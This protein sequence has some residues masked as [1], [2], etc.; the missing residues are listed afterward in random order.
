MLGRL[1]DQLLP[2]HVDS[3]EEHRH[4]QSLLHV[5]DTNGEL[6]SAL[7]R[8]PAAYPW[9]TLLPFFDHSRADLRVV[10][11]ETSATTSSRKWP[12][13]A[14]NYRMHPAN[15]TVLTRAN[16]DYTSLANNHVL[17]FQAEGMRDTCEALDRAHIAHSGCGANSEQSMRPAIVHTSGGLKVGWFSFSDH[18]TSW[19]ATTSQPGIN[20]VD[21]EHLTDSTIDR[22]CGAIREWRARELFDFT[23]VS[24]HWG[25]NYEWA[26]SANICRLAHALI[27]QAGVDVIHGT[28]S[29]HIQGVE[30]YRSKLILYGCGDFIDDY[31][32]DDEYR[33]DLSLLYLAEFARHQATTVEPETVERKTEASDSESVGSGFRLTSLE[34]VPSA[35]RVCRIH[36]PSLAE[37]RWLRERLATLSQPFGAKIEDAEHGLWR[38]AKCE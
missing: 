28:S 1:V 16:V 18:P 38:L 12:R 7:A 11:L 32:V 27:D 6:A 15:V 19:A 23:G 29:H 14:F 4:A 21:T 26:P 2:T 5:Y 31:A 30:E 13:K 36:T 37:H 8:D 10:N 34:F 24:V 20:F 9:G 3:P 35:C 33:N 25:P 17:D 22:V